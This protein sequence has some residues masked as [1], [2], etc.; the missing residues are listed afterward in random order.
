MSDN[1]FKLDIN[2]YERERRNRLYQ[3]F[4]KIKSSGGSLVIGGD[5]FDFWFNYKDSIP[6]GYIDLMEQLENIEIGFIKIDVEG[7]ELQALMGAKGLLEKNYPVIAF[8]QSE[9]TFNQGTSNVIDFLKSIGYKKFYT[10][11][12]KQDWRFKTRIMKIFEAMFL[13]IPDD[14]IELLETKYFQKKFYSMI[15]ASSE[16]IWSD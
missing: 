5:F 9:D 10:M 3:V 1:H 16:A 4:E 13:G 8:E 7:H 14:Q 11:Q 2:S 15:L 12:R 6:L